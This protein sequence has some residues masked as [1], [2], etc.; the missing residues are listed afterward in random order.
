MSKPAW[1]LETLI[2][3]APDFVNVKRY[4]Q[5][6]NMNL[7]EFIT[8]FAMHGISAERLR[9]IRQLWDGI[10]VSNHGGRQLD[11]AP[12]SVESLKT[13]PDEIHENMTVMFDSG[14]RTGLDVIR[15]KALGAQVCFSGRSF[16]YGMG[17][18]GKK[19]GEQVIGIFQDEINRTLKQIGCAA[20]AELDSSWLE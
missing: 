17:A 1:A 11:A 2:Q 19:G 8:R 7:G 9:E 20:F 16:F 5:D 14:V 18:M 10:I 4:G 13:V 6:S 3:G 15:T 12:S